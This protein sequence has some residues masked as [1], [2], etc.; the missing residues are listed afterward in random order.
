VRR[1]RLAA[2]GAGRDR[3]IVDQTGRT[4]GT[5]YFVKPAL[6][7][8]AGMDL[9][10]LNRVQPHRLRA[11]ILEDLE[12][13]PDSSS[14]EIHRRIGPEIA[15]RTFSRALK[16]LTDDGAVVQQGTGRWTRYQANASIGQGHHDGP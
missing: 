8:E 5:R 6:V 16:G 4:Q 14:A 11:L 9:R 13:Y 3:G 10:T 1:W 7:P 2:V 12:R 15:R